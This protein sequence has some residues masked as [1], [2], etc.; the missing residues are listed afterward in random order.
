MISKDKM[1]APKRYKQFV[2]NVAV[3]DLENPFTEIYGGSILGKK[4]FVKQALSTLKEGVLSRKE[5]SHRK[6]LVES[7]FEPE[8][9]INAVSDYFGIE[10]EAVRNDRKKYRNICVYIMKKYTG[11]TNGQIGRN[12]NDLSYSAVSKAYQRVA[13]TVEEKKVMR[14]DVK[15]IILILS[16]FKG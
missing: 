9:V 7:A 8:L 2:E 1:K 12:F 14:K 16:Q 6:V 11:M 13:Q 3:D 10:K 5:T 15:K 4:S